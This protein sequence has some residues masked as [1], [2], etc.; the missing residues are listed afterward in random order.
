MKL[1]W[2]NLKDM[3]L[4]KQGNLRKSGLAYIEAE[5]C[6]TCG[7]PYL[8]RMSYFK[9][10]FERFCSTECYSKSKIGTTHTNNTKEK[11]SNSN[12]GKHSIKGRRHTKETKR[13]LSLRQLG[14]KH[15]N[16]KGGVSKK[17][18]PLFNTYASKISFAEEVRGIYKYKLKV[19]QVRCTK[20]GK[21]FIPSAGSVW[22]RIR[23]LEGRKG[24]GCRF[25]CSDE[26]KHN[27]DIYGQK[28]YPK[29]F[30]KITEYTNNEL[31]I[32]RAEVLKR[33]NYKCEYCGEQATDAHHERPKKLEP[34][35][36]LDPDYGIA[37]CK[38]CHYK[39][40]H[41]DECSTGNLSSIECNGG[42][43]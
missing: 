5:S 41:K 30:N 6:K 26:C 1:C 40:G 13:K 10:G 20:C 35:F 23:V 28:K 21:W 32:W 34:F 19:L 9:N 38:E 2:D 11:I 29:W 22:R 17:D 3:Y 33:V 16:Y 43:Q 27:C 42:L 36:S 8:A 39:Y 14:N 12:K 31:Q 37:C 4:S 15:H 25:Y 18:I 24:G 7:E